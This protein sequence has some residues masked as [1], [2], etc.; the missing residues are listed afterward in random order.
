MTKAEMDNEVMDAIRRLDELRKT[1]NCLARRVDRSVELLTEAKNPN[2]P[3]VV[4]IPD[5]GNPLDDLR[6]LIDARL[7]IKETVEFLY[8]QG[9]GGVIK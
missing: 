9:L 4:D 2:S 3:V 5:S 6:Q 7:K 8:A 1:E